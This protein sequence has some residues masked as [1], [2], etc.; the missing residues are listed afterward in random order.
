MN[1]RNRMSLE[2]LWILALC[3]CSAITTKAKVQPFSDLKIIRSC[4]PASPN[5]TAIADAQA[6]SEQSAHHFNRY[7]KGVTYA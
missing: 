1:P 5:H 7:G 4:M 3:C 2:A 6:R